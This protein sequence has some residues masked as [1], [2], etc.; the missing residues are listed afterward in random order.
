[1][2]STVLGFQMATR[3][4][5]AWLCLLSAFLLLAASGGWLGDRNLGSNVFAQNPLPS[6]LPQG[7][8]VQLIALPLPPTETHQGFVIIDPVERVLSVYHVDVQTGSV[9]LKSVRR[10]QWDLK[11]SEY[12]GQDP[13]PEQIRALVEQR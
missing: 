6:G 9:A 10:I 3:S 13:L 5:L 7:D 1:M 12:N 2:R 11:M 8:H 4:K